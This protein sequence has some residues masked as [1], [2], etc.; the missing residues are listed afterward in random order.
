M[1]RAAC[2][3][4]A[5]LICC[6]VL[7]GCASYPNPAGEA[8]HTDR[9]LHWIG[10]WV[11]RDDRHYL[12]IMPVKR[13]DHYRL[14]IKQGSPRPRHYD[15][16]MVADG[17]DFMQDDSAAT[18]RPSNGENSRQP[19][20]ATLDNCLQVRHSDNRPAQTYCQRPATSDALPLQRG[21]YTRVRAHCWNAGPADRIYYNGTGIAR[22]DQRA[23]RAS[24]MNQQGIIY[25]LADSCEQA[26][27][28]HR[29]TRQ[30]RVTVADDTHFALQPFDGQTTL[31]QYCPGQPIPN[32]IAGKPQ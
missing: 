29:S 28:G 5:S 7:T 31:Y 20:L 17:L 13:S 25:T 6:L 19:A 8:K 10:R 1:P 12:Q 9:A 21:S 18:I 30:I 26:V 24:I 16:W 11:G 4:V 14:T 15:A 2:T 23:C 32:S 27:S 3:T 22:S